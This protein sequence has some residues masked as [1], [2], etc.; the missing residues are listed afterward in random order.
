MED[1]ALLVAVT[2]SAKRLYRDIGVEGM[3]RD[4]PP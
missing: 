1:I 3:V 4:K 2:A